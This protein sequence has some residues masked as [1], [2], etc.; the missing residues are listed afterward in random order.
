MK[1]DELWEA[2]LLTVALSLGV[3]GISVAILNLLGAFQ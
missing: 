3:F 2:I 1:D